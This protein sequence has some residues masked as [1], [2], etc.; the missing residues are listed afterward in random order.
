M[1]LKC[2]ARPESKSWVWSKKSWAWIAPSCSKHSKLNLAVLGHTHTHVHTLLLTPTKTPTHGN[3]T[4]TPITS[5]NKHSLAV[6]ATSLFLFSLLSLSLS[7]SLSQLVFSDSQSSS[8]H[9][10]FFAKLF[11]TMKRAKKMKIVICAQLFISS[12]VSLVLWSCSTDTDIVSQPT[13]SVQRCPER[14]GAH[15]RLASSNT[16][17]A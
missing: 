1:K 15:S 16:K 13:Q 12:E 17:L 6:Q 7:E 11:Q 5:H 2:F 3:H 4:H 14:R 10:H 9:F 8:S